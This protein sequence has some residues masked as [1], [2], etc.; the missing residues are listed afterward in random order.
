MEQS[1]SRLTQQ[2]SVAPPCRSRLYREMG[3]IDCSPST[4]TSWRGQVAGLLKRADVA[5]LYRALAERGR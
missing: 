3:S 1:W 4:L 2:V 5:A